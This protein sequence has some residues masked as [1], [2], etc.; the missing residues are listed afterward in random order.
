M[1]PENK[2]YT[3]IKKKKVNVNEHLLLSL[4]GSIW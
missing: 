4:Y 1:T 2:E 3:E